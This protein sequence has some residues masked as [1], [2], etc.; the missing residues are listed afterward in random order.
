LGSQHEKGQRNYRDQRHRF[1]HS[2]LD[3][4]SPQITVKRD[5]LACDR[6]V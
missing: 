5:R 6:E 1:D 3:E 2:D 4:I